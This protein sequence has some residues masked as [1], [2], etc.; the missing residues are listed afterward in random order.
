MP[1]YVIS[2]RDI[3]HQYIKSPL[4]N[5]FYNS[6]NLINLILDFNKSIA[7][8][9]YS[10]SELVLC[11]YGFGD[12]KGI[13]L[14]VIESLSHVKTNRELLDNYKFS[15]VIKDFNDKLSTVNVKTILCPVKRHIIDI[16]KEIYS[17][18]LSDDEYT[19]ILDK[20]NYKVCDIITYTLQI[21]LTNIDEIFICQ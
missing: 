19:N 21:K 10:L 17:I 20:V 12:L 16:L 4:L 6:G 11:R 9:V 5:Q 14:E 15:V 2:G 7:R 3:V 18:L 1:E 8:F 13:T